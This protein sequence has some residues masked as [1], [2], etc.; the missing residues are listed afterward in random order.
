MKRIEEN[1]EAINEI[2]KQIQEQTGDPKAGFRKLF[3]LTSGIYNIVIPI[4]YRKPTKTGFTQKTHEQNVMV[5]FCPFTG[6]PLY[7][8]ETVS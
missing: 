6:K 1:W 8:E 4:I 3:S 5:R 2:E 7:Q